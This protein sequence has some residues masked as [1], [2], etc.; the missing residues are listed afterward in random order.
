MI[1]GLIALVFSAA[2]SGAAIYDNWVEQPARM[3]LDD[4]ALLSEWRPSDSRGVA[5]L[6]VTLRPEVEVGPGGLKDGFVMVS[7][8]GPSRSASGVATLRWR[9]AGRAG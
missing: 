7:G 6:S 5:L 4:N 1:S 3:A 9:L 2:F 8:L